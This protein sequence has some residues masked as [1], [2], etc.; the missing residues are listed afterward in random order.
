MKI[1]AVN[2]SPRKDKNTATLLQSAL[3]G[4]RSACGSDAISTEIIHL[5]DIDYKSC[6]S[7]FACKRLGGASYGRCAINDGL[8]PVLQ[9]LAHADGII[10]GSPIY[11]GNI[12]GKM[13]SFFERLLF[14]YCVYDM[15]YSSIAPRRMP[16]AFIYTMN[17][18]KEIMEQL[19]YKETL[20]RM[21][22]VTGKTFSAPAGVMYACNTYQ[23]DDYSKYKV[24]C[25]PEPEK[26][27]YREQQFPLDCRQAASIGANIVEK[28][29]ALA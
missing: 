2:G 11:F 15:A 29:L 20:Q 8:A 13:T 21:E 26:R 27:A 4:A 23:F 28:A 19:G 6:L 14:P 5:Y 10:F 7:C 12:T 25:F 22:M 18:P 17:V 16:T 9:Q 24:E 3:D 1:Y